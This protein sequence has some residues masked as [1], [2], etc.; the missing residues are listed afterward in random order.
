M[1]VKYENGHNSIV[2]TYGGLLTTVISITI[3][4]ITI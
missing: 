3:E 1:P 4:M 2:F